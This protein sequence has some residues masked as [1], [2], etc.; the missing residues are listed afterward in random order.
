MMVA[1]LVHQQ[2]HLNQEVELATE[3]TVLWGNGERVW[4][5]VFSGNGWLRWWLW[6][7]GVTVVNAATLVVMVD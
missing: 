1:Q 6:S 3:E 7:G 2:D 4:W 5:W